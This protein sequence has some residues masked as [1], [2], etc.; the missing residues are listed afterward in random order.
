VD[1]HKDPPGRVT[2]VTTVNSPAGEQQNSARWRCDGS[3]A[4]VNVAGLEV[5]HLGA[6]LYAV[7]GFT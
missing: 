5:L 6:F 7:G 1:R 3:I 4:T 2:T